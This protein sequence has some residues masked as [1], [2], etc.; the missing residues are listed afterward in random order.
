MNQLILEWNELGQLKRQAIFEQQPSKVPGRVRIGQDFAQSD[1]VIMDGGI[2]ACHVEIFFNP[3]QQCFCIRNLIAHLS[4]VINGM[5]W[6]NSEATLHEGATVQLGAVTIAVQKIILAASQAAYYQPHQNYY[7]YN[8]QVGMATMHG[9]QSPIA[10]GDSNQLF[11]Y[12]PI[13]RLIFMSILSAGIYQS[14]WIYKNYRYL[15]E[16]D[17]LRVQAFWRG[18]FGIFFCHNLFKRIAHDRML[19]LHRPIE[20][21]PNML[22]TVWVVLQIIGII[23]SFDINAY[24]LLGISWISI[25]MSIGCFIPLQ[26]YINNANQQLNPE[27]PFSSWS[28]GDVV[29]LVVSLVGWLSLLMGAFGLV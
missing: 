20:F 19:Y 2:A 29:C 24:A 7:A 9:V 4:L 23:L 16:R 21:S 6:P 8:N 3:H 1:I 13:S 28:F 10:T 14:Y 11:Y 5:V 18:I 27:Q 22:A 15:K 25:L 26:N 17:R 12:I